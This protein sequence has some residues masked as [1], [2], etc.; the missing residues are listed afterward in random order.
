M[1]RKNFVGGHKAQLV[2]NK[3]EGGFCMSKKRKNVGLNVQSDREMLIKKLEVEK[4]A[5]IEEKLKGLKLA[6]QTDSLT[7]P[8]TKVDINT[9]YGV[10]T[11]PWAH[12][13]EHE[14]IDLKTPVILGR[15][16]N[17]IGGLFQYFEAKERG[18]KQIDAVYIDS[19]KGKIV[20]ISTLKEQFQDKNICISFAYSLYTILFDE[21]QYII[22][23][24]E[25]YE[26]FDKLFI[27]ENV[28]LRIYN[29]ILA[30]DEAFGG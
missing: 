26:N 17:V 30:L 13:W 18:L 19:L 27:Q 2:R 21:L 6:N 20:S 1:Y 16:R 4:I 25:F 5:S 28:C 23:F 10:T 29:Y 7:I 14:K 12:F 11:H 3:I 22:G 8:T 15:E 9:L 24:S